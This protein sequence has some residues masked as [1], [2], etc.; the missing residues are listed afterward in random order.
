MF[1]QLLKVRSFR[2]FSVAPSGRLD[3]VW[4]DT[5]NAANNTNSQLFYFYTTQAVLTWSPNIAVSNSF[6]PFDGYP[7]G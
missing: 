3:V 1:F 6:N 5:P 4:Y 7:G 2:R